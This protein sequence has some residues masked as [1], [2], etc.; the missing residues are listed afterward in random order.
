M[1]KLFVLVILLSILNSCKTEKKT[2]IKKE[3]KTEVLVTD[4]FELIKATENQLLKKG[5][6]N[7]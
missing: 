5:I 3:T 2:S 7:S 6:Q 1:N 4:N